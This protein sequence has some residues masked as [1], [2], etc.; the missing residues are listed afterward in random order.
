MHTRRVSIEAGIDMFIPVDDDST[1]NVFRLPEKLALRILID[2]GV[3]PCHCALM[4]PGQVSPSES[5]VIGAFV[6]KKGQA[7]FEKHSR[8]PQ[9]QGCQVSTCWR[10]CAVCCVAC[11]V[12]RPRRARDS[13]ILF[14]LPL[15][16]FQLYD[17]ERRTDGVRL[18]LA[19]TTDGNDC[20]V[21]GKPPYGYRLAQSVSARIPRRSS[22]PTRDRSPRQC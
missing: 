10:C 4:P 15:P 17:Q 20:D 3:S 13:C 12:W 9:R 14:A 16:S 5:V 18:L 8:I 22:W 21:N 11:C 6:E 19:E 7:I 2:R 1:H